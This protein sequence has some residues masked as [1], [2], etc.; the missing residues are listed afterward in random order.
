MRTRRSYFPP[1]STIPRRSRKQ[2]TNV[3]EP[4]IRTIVEMADNR[5]MAQMLQAPIEGYEDWVRFTTE[6][7]ITK[8]NT[9]RDWYYVSCSKCIKK[10]IDGNNIPM[11]PDHGPEP[12]PR[13]RDTR[14]RMA[15]SHFPIP[16][17]C[18]TGRVDFYF[19]DI[20]DKPLQITESGKSSKA[21]AGDSQLTSLENIHEITEKIIQIAS[22]IQAAR[23][24]QKS[25]AD[26]RRKPL[27]FQVGYKVMLKV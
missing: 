18:K 21:L 8:I 25:N 24:R 2:T 1:T 6:A 22:K 3:V 5:T 9:S 11:C 20:L 23:D 17:I 15:P 16:L 12:N 4:E 14:N 10:V 7:T 26:V 19:D 27:E 13:Y